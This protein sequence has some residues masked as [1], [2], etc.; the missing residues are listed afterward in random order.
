MTR[1]FGIAADVG[2]TTMALELVELETGDVAASTSLSNP[3]AQFGA[4]VMTRIAFAQAAPAN[5]NELHATLVRALNGMIADA[6]A[7]AAV[8]RD[9]VHAAVFVGNATMM[10][11]L[12]GIDPTPL[13][14]APYRGVLEAGWQGRAAA[15]GFELPRAALRV[16]Q[17]IRSHVGADTVAA[18]LAT[19]FDEA[20]GSALLIDLG[21][22][23]EV[24]LTHEGRMLC[25]STA[26][27]P[28]FESSNDEK[29]LPGS[30]L[31]SIV[32]EG[33]RT[34][35][36]DASGRSQLG[37]EVDQQYVRQ[38]QL[39]KAG[40][41]AGVHILLARAGL[42]TRQIDSIVLAGAFGNYIVADD[43]IRIG[44]LP[45]VPVDRVRFAAD[46]ALAGARLLLMSPVAGERAAT[47]ARRIR[48]VELGGHKRYADVFV[49]E[50]S[51][52]S[53]RGR[54]LT[55]LSQ[56]TAAVTQQ[57][58]QR[59]P[60]RAA[61]D[62][63]TFRGPCRNRVHVQSRSSRCGGGPLNVEPV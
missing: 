39:A 47:M 42:E 27:G 13:G 50:I 17:G 1:R 14:V 35:A 36:I 59:C 61:S 60:Y 16:P 55:E 46:A 43:A 54:L 45:S 30:H 15:I 44:L 63:C 12:M 24:V 41:A 51:F 52:P 48:Y 18:I 5:A 8:A 34:G 7:N 21:T 40:V 3:Q 29:T 10:H 58:L 32:A 11:T 6:L 28:A 53:A 9:D 22:N 56:L 49:E 38:L 20:G 33:L 37:S 19:G 31:I 26:A 2:T 25:T 4:D 62:V 57:S 23:S